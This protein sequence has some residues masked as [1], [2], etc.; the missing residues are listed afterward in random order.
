MAIVSSIHSSPAYWRLLKTV[1][2]T[3]RCECFTPSTM[4][5]P[6]RVR[7]ARAVRSS[8]MISGK[9]SRRCFRLPS[10]YESL[11]FIT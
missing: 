1:S 9:P 4:S 8:P 7:S 3:E 6:M 2:M 11:A 10:Q 5:R